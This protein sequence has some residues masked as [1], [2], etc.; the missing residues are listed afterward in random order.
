MTEIT[1][2]DAN[3]NLPNLIEPIG[4][5]IAIWTDTEHPSGEPCPDLLV[6]KGCDGEWP[7]RVVA[8]VAAELD[9]LAATMDR[10][11][12][13]YHVLTERAMNLRGGKPQHVHSEECMCEMGPMEV[14]GAE[15]C[16]SCGGHVGGPC[17]A[18]CAVARR[19]I[20]A[21]QPPPLQWH[22]GEQAVW[23]GRLVQVLTAPPMG[24]IEFDGSG[25]R[26]SVRMDELELLPEK[27]S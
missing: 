23:R 2:D 16:S 18:R 22:R 6:C 3:G 26:H 1:R 13:T 4:N 19:E 24:V 8:L 14:A 12:H 21:A 10:P 20:V 9:R 11:S 17:G 27:R 7:C 5:H 15:E 25:E